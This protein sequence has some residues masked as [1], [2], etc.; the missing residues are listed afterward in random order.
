[1]MVDDTVEVPP[2]ADNGNVPVD[3]P[4]APSPTPTP[5]VPADKGAEADKPA[6]AADP[7]LYEL[8]DGR[9]VNGEELAKEWKEN[10]LP[11]YTRKSQALAAKEKVDLPDKP[12]NKYADPAYVPQTYEEIIQAAEE[13]AL[14]KFEAKEQSRIDQQKAIEDAVESQLTEIK[15]ADPTV[16][17][18][19]LFQH[20]NKYGFRDLKTAHQNMR[21]MGDVI[22][23]T[24]KITAD[25]ITKRNDPVSAAPG[26]GGGKTEAS[27]FGTARDYLRSL[28]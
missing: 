11:D 28:K 20:A 8:P 19:A 2:S 10:F 5:D 23:K 22:K 1:M 7:M 6:V 26:A 4:P 27:N 15:K 9:K 3:T 12:Q 14:Q 16:D 21:D 25:N 13:R 17:E 24:Q 18:N